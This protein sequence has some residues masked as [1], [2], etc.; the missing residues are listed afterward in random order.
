MNEQRE[1]VVDQV[2]F[3]GETL[4]PLFLYDPRRD[5]DVVRPSI[6][7]FAAL[8]VEAAAREWPLAKGVDQVAE[9]LQLM[10]EGAAEGK[11]PEGD[12]ALVWE[13]RRLFVGPAAK[14]APPWGSVYTDHECVTCGMSTL[15]L[16][17]WM[18]QRGIER[19]GDASEPEDH[20]GLMLLLMAWIADNRPEV[21]D[22]YLRDHLLTWAD[23][24][25]EELDQA[26]EHSFY[27][28]LARLAR[29]S[30]A[31]VKDALGLE[32]AYPRFYR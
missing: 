26:A 4:G 31:G 27:R 8:D 16:R 7:A 18:R 28:G 24:F 17:Q 30:L 32:V 29:L 10:R 14:A 3:L 5:A 6:D 9:A 23:H 22:E 12:D 13:Y 11:T 20:I 1:L 15:A 25:L 2:A 21:L 19:L